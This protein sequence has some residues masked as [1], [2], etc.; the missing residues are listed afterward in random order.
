M[1]I[2]RVLGC[3][4]LERRILM[5]GEPLPTSGDIDGNGQ[6]DNFDINQISAHWG[7]DNPVAD[8]NHD[9]SVNIFDTNA[10][11]AAWG[12]LPHGTDLVKQDEHL[13]LLSVFP[14][15]DA[16]DIAIHDGDW[17]DPAIW[18]D[19]TVPT[20]GEKVLL[21]SNV[22]LSAAD[23]ADVTWIRVENDFDIAGGSLAVGTLMGTPTSHLDIEGGTV[24]FFGALD[25]ATDPYEFGIGMVWHGS[26]E[27]HDAAF[28]TAPGSPD[29]G[30]VM[31]MHNP[32]VGV[33]DSSFTDLGRSRKDIAITDPDGQGGGL[34]NV[35]GRYALHF[36]RTGYDT[37]AIVENCTIVNPSSWG[38]V[39]HESY[40]N[41]YDTTVTGAFGAAFM[42]ETGTELGTFTRCTAIDVDGAYRPGQLDEDH[43]EVFGLAANND[44]A[45][46][47]AGFWS[48]SRTVTFDGNYVE[49][50]KD[51]AYFILARSPTQDTPFTFIN[52]AA[53]NADRLALVI[54]AGGGLPD[55]TTTGQSLVAHNILHGAVSLGYT[56]HVDFID[57]QIIGPG[58]LA[59]SWR[60]PF[61]TGVAHSGVS[62]NHRWIDNTITDWSIGIVL[63]SE[64]YNQVQGGYY[65][66][67]VVD[68]RI[69]NTQ[70]NR[71]REIVMAGLQFGDK[72]DWHIEMDPEFFSYDFSGAYKIWAY[73]NSYPPPNVAPIFTTSGLGADSKVYLDGDLLAFDVQAA[74]FSWDLLRYPEYWGKT[75]SDLEDQGL[76]V[77]GVALPDG[78]QYH[79]P[80]VRGVIV[81][82]LMAG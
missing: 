59:T 67:F 52:N 20:A 50:A 5:H 74:D 1:R 3:E 27:I 2:F 42:V 46:T 17:N 70:E 28:S 41:V 47:G 82:E 65:D 15:T 29:R 9:G 21:L 18:Y 61:T 14:R 36:H 25:T 60:G 56:G 44:V 11:S 51:S 57:N 35:R 6:V 32:N 31:F 10:V 72:A 45:Y 19:G 37:P 23:A 71:P 24:Q 68:I 64:G 40:V 4:L 76:I 69:F 73:A 58:N 78:A 30:H 22:E 12:T 26:A 38:V 49:N 8:A 48:N 79:L 75:T 54:W 43:A 7:S 34:E 16:T 55:D 33:Y 80:K 77:G 81:D 13:E 62:Y 63:G 39:N 66:N 53:N